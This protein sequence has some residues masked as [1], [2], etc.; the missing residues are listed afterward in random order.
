M[1]RQLGFSLVELLAALAITGLVVS[2][3][4]TA[5][6]QMLSVTQY[7]NARLTASHELQNAAHWFSFDG[8]RASSASGGSLLTLTLS[9]NSFITYSLTGTELQRAAAGSSMTLARNITSVDFAVDNRF[10][11]MNLTSSPEGRWSVTENGTYR[12]YL[13]PAG[14]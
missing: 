2:G 6:Y 10:I 13:R 11:T 8:Q 14:E 12:V 7:G 3:L 9:D 5:I 4:G 1:K